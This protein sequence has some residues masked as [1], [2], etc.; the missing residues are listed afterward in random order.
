MSILKD[1]IEILNDAK[2][3]IQD[4]GTIQY[5][6][7]RSLSERSKDGILEFPIIIGRDTDIETAMMVSKAL[8]RNYA[9]MIQIVASMN[10]V[11]KVSDVETPQEFVKLFHS[12]SKG[13]ISESV[14][15]TSNDFTRL[16]TV[17]S[18]RN[19]TRVVS[20]VYNADTPSLNKLLK[21]SNVNLLES[22][23]GSSL[24]HSLKER[25][26]DT[27]YMFKDDTKNRKYNAPVMEK[28]DRN[29]TNKRNVQTADTS[30]DHDEHENTAYRDLGH[31]ITNV[32]DTK[33]T[34][35]FINNV[36]NKF[37]INLKTP[38]STNA[39]NALDKAKID[40]HSK[41]AQTVT[42]RQM[43]Q[44]N[45]AKKANELV[46][47]TVHIVIKQLSNDNLYAGMVD[48][49]IGVKGKLHPV[50]TEDIM[51]QLIKANERKG[52]LFNILRWT[53]GEISFVKDLLLAVDD[54]KFDN[55]QMSKESSGKYNWFRRLK[56]MKRRS[57]VS[58]VLKMIG[59]K[60][61]VILPNANIV[62]SEDTAD[63]LN[64]HHSVDVHNIRTVK[65]IVEDLFLLG[66]TIVDH[67]AQCVYFYFRGDED[68]ETITFSSLEKE[69]SNEQRKFKEMLKVINRV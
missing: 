46:S 45:D 18:E 17:V 6:D 24:N 47:T 2:D 29:R 52:V 1:V 27:I 62:I 58:K 22:L 10:S 31:T 4:A 42:S 36:D 3:G 68:F 14:D 69:N 65:Q 12:N 5:S 13:L 33:V 49:I 64:I 7:N 53:T 23:H 39:V 54:A 37:D 20:T 44:D 60:N 63:Q 25:G 26:R 21:E 38:S 61:N 8:E 48:F 15:L 43:L 57:D 35:K 32:N 16:G 59:A 11:V 41:I 9:T 51:L 67:A 19:G 40:A 28:H 30:H 55:L 34:P 56:E 66:F 50:D